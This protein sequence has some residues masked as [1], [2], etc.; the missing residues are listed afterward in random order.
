MKTGVYTATGAK[1]THICYCRLN[2][3][4]LLCGFL[5]R[6]ETLKLQRLQGLQQIYRYGICIMLQYVVIS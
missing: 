3:I 2:D 4:V 5:K 1:A 6:A